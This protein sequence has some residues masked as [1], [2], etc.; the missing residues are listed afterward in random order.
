MWKIIDQIDYPI[1]S[2]LPVLFNA[3]KLTNIFSYQ[4]FLN[5]ADTPDTSLT[6]YIQ[7]DV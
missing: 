7:G 1:E 6:A 2:P 3:S 4:I 5:K